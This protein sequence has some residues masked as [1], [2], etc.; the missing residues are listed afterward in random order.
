MGIRLVHYSVMTNH[1][2]FVCEVQDEGALSRGI[3]GLS[4]RIARALNRIWKRSGRVFADRYHAHVLK[5]PREV[6]IVLAYVLRNAT[7]H[8][9][10]LVGPD[11][12]SSGAG[13]DGWIGLPRGF[14]TVID[15]AFPTAVTWLLALGWRRHGL[16]VM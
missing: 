10:H 15:T 7:H 9:I 12:C 2:H 16:I 11:P 8:G 14:C 13:F 6:R 3:K 4:V 5:T 1:L